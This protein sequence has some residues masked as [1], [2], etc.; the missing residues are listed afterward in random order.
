[1]LLLLVVAMV[2]LLLL[3]AEV[4]QGTR[5]PGGLPPSVANRGGV[6]FLQLERL[7]VLR[8]GKPFTRTLMWWVSKGRPETSTYTA[9]GK[10]LT[11]LVTRRR[12][13]TAC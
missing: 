3:L 10:Y 1:V 11:I 12:N 9:A 6:S 13:C 4:L 7:R 2:L 8:C 5:V